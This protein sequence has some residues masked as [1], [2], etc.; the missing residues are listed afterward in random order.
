MD[1]K[2]KE[3][4]YI[5]ILKSMDRKAREKH[6][7]DILDVARTFAGEKLGFAVAEPIGI[8]ESSKMDERAWAI[9]E[10]LHSK[11][12]AKIYLNRNLSGYLGISTVIGHELCHH[13]IDTYVN[14][15]H[16]S[17]GISMEGHF[18]ETIINERCFGKEYIESWA[19]AAAIDKIYI[20][21]NEGSCNLFGHIFNSLTYG[22]E[23][24]D[25][26]Y[27]GRSYINNMFRAYNSIKD[28]EG[29]GIIEKLGK[30]ISSIGDDCQREGDALAAMSFLLN[31]SDY[32][33][34]IK[35]LIRKKDEVINDLLVLAK[36]DN[37][38]IKG[39]LDYAYAGSRSYRLLADKFRQR[40][41]GI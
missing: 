17:H 2:V 9:Y 24:L 26:F 37:D 10:T 16:T 23:Y 12:M 41:G 29:K 19:K 7:A 32:V 4:R 27:T 39:F 11:G 8:T 33:K 5:E 21:I 31:D 30:D 1:R 15:Q 22:L 20:S 40:Q 14:Y 34:T 36:E 13:L 35:F 3:K 38:K 25:D 6:Y 28:N 18:E